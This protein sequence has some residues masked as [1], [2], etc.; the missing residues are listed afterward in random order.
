MRA[1]RALTAALPLV[2]GL[3]GAACAN[4][5]VVKLSRDPANVV[6]PSITYN[7]WN[8]STLDQITPSN[9]KQLT[10]NWTLQIGLLESHEASPLVIGNTMYLISPR[11]NFLVAFDL[12]QDGVFLWEFRPT[13]DS[14][15]NTVLNCCGSSPRG[16]YYAEN[17]V[18]FAGVDGHLFA[19]DA[20]SGEQVWR[21]AAADA[22][23][24]ETMQGNGLVVGRNFLAA[25]DGYGGRGKVVAADLN[26]GRVAWTRTNIGPNADV[27]IGPKFQKTYPYLSGANPAQDSW[28]GDSWQRGGANAGGFFTYDAET[29]LVFHAT[30]GCRPSNPDYRRERGKVELTAAGQLTAFHNNFCSAQMARDATTGELVWAYTL[31]P[32]DQWGLDELGI[33]PLVDLDSG[34]AAL[35]VSANGLVYAWDRATGKL[36]SEPFAHSFQDIIKSVDMTTGLPAYDVDKLAFTA[37]EDRRRVT[38]AD[39]V[40]GE[41]RPADYTGTEIVACPAGG[42]RKWEADAYSPRTKLIYTHTNNTCVASV[43]IAGEYKAGEAYSLVRRAAIPNVPRKDVTGQATTNLSELKAVD[44]VGRKI[45][46]SRP[47]GDDT[48]T[49][50]LVT[51]GDVLF[52]GN[53]ANGLIEAYDARSGEPLWSFR[54]GSG[55]SQS[56]VTY[57]REGRQYVAIVASSAQPNVGVGFNTAPDAA[58]RQRRGGTTMYVFSLPQM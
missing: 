37:V 31:T 45:A 27:G 33:T 42:A 29:N 39:P 18:F 23:K 3:A 47:M 46:W 6:M 50:Q 4:D 54:S 25:S 20:R 35:R 2:M 52:K 44:P 28:F 11:Q 22:T 24:G 21:S 55:F 15:A 12:A 34:K 43:A 53:N 14:V 19:V 38:Q 32:Q 58:A 41:R 26:T 1:L 36:L 5:D 7:G 9:A 17:K 49:P 56:P 48:R 40:A 30:G 10:L 13:L 8:Y 51:A 16:L 57:L